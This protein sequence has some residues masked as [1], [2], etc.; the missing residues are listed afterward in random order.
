MNMN[1]QQYYQL[2]TKLAAEQVKYAGN[3][4]GKFIPGIALPSAIGGATIGG[5]FSDDTLSGM[6]T[7]AL[8]GLGSSLGLVGGSRLGKLLANRVTASKYQEAEKAVERALAN[9][10][11]VGQ[12][13]TSM[14]ME[15]LPYKPLVPA[16][17]EARYMPKVNARLEEAQ[18]LLAEQKR[19]WRATTYSSALGGAAGGIPLP[20]IAGWTDE[21]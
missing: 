8:A 10:K 4:W 17:L 5:L 6:S 9:K 11:M 1:L 3:L 14:T 13:I 2:G 20:W 21:Q 7:G 18:K 15:H 12:H 19:R 16:E